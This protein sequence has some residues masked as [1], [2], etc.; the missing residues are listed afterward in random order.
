VQIAEKVKEIELQEGEVE[1]VALLLPRICL[2]KQDWTDD[3]TTVTLARL[4][5]WWASMNA[6]GATIAS[7]FY[8]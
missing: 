4:P 3:Y 6:A 5:K 1:V 2:R 8:M 7:P